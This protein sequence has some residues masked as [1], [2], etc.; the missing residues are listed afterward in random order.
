[1]KPGSN[2]LSLQFN[3]DAVGSIGSADMECVI[4][5]KFA[6]DAA[7]GAGTCAHDSSVLILVTYQAQLAQA[8]LL[9]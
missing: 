3:I 1:M 2:L 7:A 8:M 6:C 9:F 5:E 4:M